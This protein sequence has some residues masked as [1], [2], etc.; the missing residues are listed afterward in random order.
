MELAYIHKTFN[1]S[2][3]FV[4]YSF[5]SRICEALLSLSIVSF[6]TCLVCPMFLYCCLPSEG[7]R[8]G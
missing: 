6:Y 4:K 7:E 1:I 5:D 3:F 2:P 8:E